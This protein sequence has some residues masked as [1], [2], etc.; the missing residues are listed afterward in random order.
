M[1]KVNRID[2]KKGGGVFKGKRF[3]RKQEPSSVPK[4]CFQGLNDQ[5]VNMQKF[6]CIY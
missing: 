1:L 4:K 6:I 3:D 5:A 2:K